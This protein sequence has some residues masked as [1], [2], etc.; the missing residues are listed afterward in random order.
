MNDRRKSVRST[1]EDAGPPETRR[2]VDRH[3]LDPGG[4]TTW[5]ALSASHAR[6]PRHGRPR[7]QHRP[8]VQVGEHVDQDSIRCNALARSETTASSGTGA[9]RG[10]A[11]ES[12]GLAGRQ[13]CR[14]GRH[15][16][17]DRGG[18]S[19]R[20]ATTG[21]RRL[22]ATKLPPVKLPR[23]PPPLTLTDLDQ[24]RSPA[25]RSI[26]DFRHLAYFVRNSSTAVAH[27]LCGVHKAL[28][29]GPTRWLTNRCVVWKPD[30][31]RCD[32]CAPNE[33]MHVTIVD[34]Y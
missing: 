25:T 27:Q 15:Q 29:H 16:P 24:F 20:T 10:P 3:Q 5:A 7:P 22:W 32:G 13:S 30:K 9:R 23:S 18:W 19:T 8:G 21:G 6:R 26:C 12:G 11:P 34:Q 1:A 2:R 4:A 33:I 17:P 31:A 14:R 28:N